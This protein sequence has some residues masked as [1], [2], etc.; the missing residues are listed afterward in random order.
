MRRSKT[1]CTVVLAVTGLAAACTKSE[2]RA[3]PKTGPAPSGKRVSITVTENGFEPGDIKVTKGQP[4]TFVFVRKTDKTCAKEVVIHV[5][6]KNKIEKKLPLN[7]P[8]E[9][10]VTFPNSGDVKYACGMDM[11]T[12]V[13]H[14]Q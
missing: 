13:V 12:G 10:A 5:D 6:Q 2:V 8:V 1:L 11:I 4:V 14:V 7:K 9:V 3:D